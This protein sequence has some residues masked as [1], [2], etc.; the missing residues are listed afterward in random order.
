MELTGLNKSIPIAH[1]TQRPQ[2][3]EGDKAGRHEGM[4]DGVTRARKGK[5]QLYDRTHK[6][7]IEMYIVCFEL[8]IQ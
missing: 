3:K 8:V 2:T 5:V 4:N 1:V 6:E 7:A